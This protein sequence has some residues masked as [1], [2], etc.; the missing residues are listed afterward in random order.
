[1]LTCW[2]EVVGDRSLKKKSYN[3]GESTAASKPCSLSAAHYSGKI[4]PSLTEKSPR[5][6]G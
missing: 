2:E 4:E 6:V 5:R 3:R 1:M